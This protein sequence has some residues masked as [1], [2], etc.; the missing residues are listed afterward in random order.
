MHDCLTCKARGCSVLESCDEPTLMTISAFKFTKL[1][2]RGQ[3][4]VTEG[5]PVEGIYFIKKGVLKTVLT[6]RNNKPYLF[7]ISGTGS[8]FGY[9]MDTEQSRHPG[10]VTALS[11]VIYCYVPNRVF[12][13]ITQS[14]LLLRRQIR[15]LF[16]VELNQLRQSAISLA[17]KKVREKIAEA[18]LMLV[19]IYLKEENSTVF[20]IDLSRQ[21]IADLTGTTKEQVSKTLKDFEREGLLNCNGRKFNFINQ[22]KLQFIAGIHTTGENQKSYS[23]KYENVINGTSN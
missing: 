23:K 19:A 6:G 18:L 15:N 7:R 11:D 5:D 16:L 17:H 10:T 2:Q 4:L 14:N 12:D 9:R 13:N 8:V 1:L 3:R 21:D 22:L 20:S